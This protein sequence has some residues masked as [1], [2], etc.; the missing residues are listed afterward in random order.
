M[1][2]TASSAR[3][4]ASQPTFRGKTASSACLSSQDLCQPSQIFRGKPSSRSFPSSASQSAAPL[5]ASLLY[6]P[7]LPATSPRPATVE[8]SSPTV[9]RQFNPDVLSC[10]FVLVECLPNSVILFSVNFSTVNLLNVC[11]FINIPLILFRYF[12][13]II[14]VKFHS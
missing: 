12:S 1:S 9:K 2:V 14:S 11:C 13:D 3:T 5:E 6:Y 8:V 7:T 4:S 10:I